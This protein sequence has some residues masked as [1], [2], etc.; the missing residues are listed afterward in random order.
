[1]L[2]PNCQLQQR[3]QEAHLQSVTDKVSDTSLSMLLNQDLSYGEIL[4]GQ[5][6]A[7][8]VTKVCFVL[9]QSKL[10]RK[11]KDQL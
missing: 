11:K 6:G 10:K 9:M 4:A 5:R 8:L 1:M 3:N 7:W 2:L